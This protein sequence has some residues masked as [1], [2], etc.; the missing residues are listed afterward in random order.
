M[1]LVAI[2]SCEQC[3]SCFEC[4]TA[5]DRVKKCYHP[6]VESRPRL[7]EKCSPIPKWCPLPDT[8][9]KD[10]DIEKKRQYDEKMT[11]AYKIALERGYIDLGDAP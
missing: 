10:D 8:E 7:I 5:F 1:K 3:L 6:A 2:N 11:Y 4:G 9:C